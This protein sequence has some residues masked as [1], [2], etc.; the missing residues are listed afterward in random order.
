MAYGALHLPA[1]SFVFQWV[2]TLD[3]AEPVQ[4]RTGPTTTYWD[5][6][7]ACLCATCSPVIRDFFESALLVDDIRLWPVATGASGGVILGMLGRG[8]YLSPRGKGQRPHCGGTWRSPG[9]SRGLPRIRWLDDL[10]K[11]K[12]LT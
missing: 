5:G 8:S 12:V 11:R 2:H 6:V 4:S 3:L 1:D 10:Q 9:S 7:L